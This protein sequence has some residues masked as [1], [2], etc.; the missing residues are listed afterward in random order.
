MKAWIITA[1]CL[2]AFSFAGATATELRV[3]AT[4]ACAFPQGEMV[5]GGDKYYGEAGLILGAGPGG[6]VRT[7]IRPWRFFEVEIGAD[8]VKLP[9]D[10]SPAEGTVIPI[11][12]GVNLVADQGRY[13]ISCGGGAGYYVFKATAYG[14]ILYQIDE[15]T[16]EWRSTW[17]KVSLTGPGIYYGFAASVRFGRWSLDFTPRWNQIFNQGPHD[18]EA[19]GEYDGHK[20]YFDL[21]YN[22]TYAEAA[23]GVSYRVF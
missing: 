16:T 22:C 5:L 20:L 19:I 4:G 2:V 14:T 17:G 9:G 7:W 15:E 6:G 21:P 3:G 10:I 12:G 1:C 18:G 13:A 11:R 23:L 8:Y